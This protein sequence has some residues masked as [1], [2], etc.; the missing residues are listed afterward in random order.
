MNKLLKISVILLIILAVLILVSLHFVQNKDNYNLEETTTPYSLNYPI[1]NYTFTKSDI[2]K[3]G[4]KW[5][6]EIIFDSK[7]NYSEIK[8]IMN[9]YFNDTGIVWKMYY[10]EGGPNN[11]VLY[12]RENNYADS[13][14]ILSEQESVDEEPLGFSYIENPKIS[15]NRDISYLFTIEGNNATK[16]NLF[17]NESFNHLNIAKTQ[18]VLLCYSGEDNDVK[19]RIVDS[20]N[21]IN[22]CY[23][24][25]FIIKENSKNSYCDP[26]YT[27]AN[28]SGRTWY[29][30]V[31]FKPGTTDKEISRILNAELGPDAA[32]EQHNKEYNYNYYIDLSQYSGQIPDDLNH[33][34]S[35]STYGWVFY[36]P[37]CFT[38]SLQYYPLTLNADSNET[39]ERIIT[40]L[41]N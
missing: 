12:S 32:F 7:I 20:L 37:V 3:L 23:N 18:R 10:Y 8:S 33:F 5:Y 14:K 21:Q 9:E 30:A 38:K 27:T 35:I 1:Q 41:E 15:E 34:S 2:V 39:K 4:E 13:F 24:D 36:E 28:N 11:Y 31:G 6:P 22:K 29:P 26:Y 19:K 16:D 40:S 25:V 17:S